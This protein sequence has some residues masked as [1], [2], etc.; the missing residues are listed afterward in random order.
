MD[1]DWVLSHFCPLLLVECWHPK[2]SFCPFYAF[3]TVISSNS[4][5][6]TCYSFNNSFIQLIILKCYW[7]SIRCKTLCWTLGV[8]SWA[9]QALCSH[10]TYILLR[11]DKWWTN[12]LT[13]KVSGSDEHWGVSKTEWCDRK[14]LGP[15]KLRG[16]RSPLWRDD[17]WDKARMMRRSQAC[18]GLVEECSKQQKQ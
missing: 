16:L 2:V 18:K 11:G 15:A 6:C 14:W 9:L 4:F 10:G 5:F 13:R 3:F 1:L 17:I 8:P 7:V 12:K